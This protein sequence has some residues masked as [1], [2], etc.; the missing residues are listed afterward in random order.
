MP[1]FHF[2]LRFNFSKSYRIASD[3]NELMLLTDGDIELKLKSGI[4]GSLLEDIPRA[5]ILGGLSPRRTKRKR[6]QNGQRDQFFFGLS[7]SASGSSSV[8]VSNATN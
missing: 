6:L 5:A 3:A 8:M 1:T 7:N 4:S 2:R